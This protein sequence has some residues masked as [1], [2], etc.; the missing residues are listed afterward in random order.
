MERW[1]FKIVEFTCV[2]RD[3]FQC[4]PFQHVL[5][6]Y[7]VWLG[8]M[9]LHH[10]KIPYNHSYSNGLRLIVVSITSMSFFPPA[11]QLISVFLLIFAIIFI[12]AVFSFAFLSYFFDP[13]AGHFCTSLGECVVTVLREG[14]LGTITTVRIIVFQLSSAH[15]VEF[16]FLL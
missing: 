5:H 16:P 11:K 8:L 3:H 2:D 14:L 4:D 9:Q 15:F 12:Y 10:C 7:T 13:T 6:T 1:I